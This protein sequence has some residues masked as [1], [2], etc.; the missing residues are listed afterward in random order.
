MYCA[1]SIL[2]SAVTDYGRPGRPGFAKKSFISGTF[3]PDRRTWHAA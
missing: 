1:N 2:L 3:L